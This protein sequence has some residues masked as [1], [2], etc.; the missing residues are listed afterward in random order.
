MPAEAPRECERRFLVSDAG[1]LEGRVGCTVIQ[2]YLFSQDE[3]CVRVRREFEIEEGKDSPREK[4]PTVAIKGPRR[5]G[6]RVEYEWDVDHD[7][8]IALMMISTLKIAKTRF[9]IIYGEQLWDVDV[10]HWDNEGLIIAECETEKQLTT[11]A[12]PP[13]CGDEVTDDPSYNNEALAA[14][15]WRT[16]PGV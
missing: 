6:A 1:I 3:W 2:G 9:S 8:V 7:T 4:Q 13:W 16:R 10:F 5:G 15:P 11:I 14:N 12:I